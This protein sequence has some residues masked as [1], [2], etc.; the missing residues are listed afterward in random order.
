MLWPSLNLDGFELQ[1]V[2]AEICQ[3]DLIIFG[4]VM[5]E[6]VCSPLLFQ[7]NGLCIRQNERSE[8]LVIA[9]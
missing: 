2:V 9:V 7:I 5:H 8:S 1:G 6:R 4:G 3:P